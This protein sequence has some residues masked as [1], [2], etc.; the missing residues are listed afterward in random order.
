MLVTT[1]ADITGSYNASSSLVL[2]T[3][4]SDV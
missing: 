3:A 2:K 4:N 1:N